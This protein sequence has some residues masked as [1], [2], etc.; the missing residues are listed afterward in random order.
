MFLFLYAP[1]AC[2]L[3]KEII[4]LRDDSER[5]DHFQKI[6]KIQSTVLSDIAAQP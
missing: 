5:S 6:Q 3:T 1:T 2:N 4:S